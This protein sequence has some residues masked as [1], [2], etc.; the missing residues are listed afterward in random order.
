VPD[1]LTKPQPPTGAVIEIIERDRATDDTLG[2][3]VI[4]PN[5]ILINGQPVLTPDDKPITIHE[6]NGDELVTVTL[7]LFARRISI[8]AEHDTD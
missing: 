3:S 8:R 1:P 7:T 2:G 5:R 4:M 6:I